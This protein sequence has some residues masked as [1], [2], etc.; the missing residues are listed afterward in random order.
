MIGF[1][2]AIHDATEKV[3]QDYSNSFV[4]G[5]GVTYKNGADGTMGELSGRFPNR[6]FDTPVSEATNTGVAIG[7]AM[8][9]MRP[10]IH[11][12][13]VEFALFAA[14][15]IFTQAAK[16]NYMFGGNYPVP[17]VI[18]VAIG[19]QWG[20]GPQHT[21]GFLSLFGSTPGLR[22][23]VPSSPNQAYQLM[24]SAVRDNNPV[25]FLEPRWLYGLSGEVERA[26]AITPLDKCRIIRSG[27][28]V[29]LVSY[30]DG[31]LAAYLAAEEI[32]NQGINA[33]VIDLVSINP[34]DYQGVIESVKKTKRLIT[35]DTTSSAFSVGSEIVSKV[36][37][38]RELELIAKPIQLACPDVPCP[39]A[40][41][42][43][44][45]YY[46]TWPVVANHVLSA[47]NLERIPTELTFDD[48]N[49]A[50][51][52]ECPYV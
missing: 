44:K 47:F 34:I 35:V 46:P 30:G 50:P 18:R 48:L 31:L 36:T 19:R 4:M 42:L 32:F 12:G 49:L 37:S 21:G 38:S 51:K 2:T 13:R 20:N 52:I 6:V 17:L 24:L 5:L 22:V 29:T 8:S 27:T 15:Q 9:G 16:W 33:E 7:A 41:S 43:T 3:L 23:V 26:D 39:T 10:I 1:T 28:D 45:N 14:D 11:H 25:I 40:P